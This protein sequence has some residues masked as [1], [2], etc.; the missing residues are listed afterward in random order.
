MSRSLPSRS[1]TALR[2]SRPASAADTAAM[3]AGARTHLRPERPL[4]TPLPKGLDPF[5]L[6][7]VPA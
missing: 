7:F 3:V 1:T 2:G 6:R 5:A 4:G